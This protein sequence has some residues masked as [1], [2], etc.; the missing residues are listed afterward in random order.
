M[1][2]VVSS[3]LLITFVTKVVNELFVLRDCER[4]LEDE[5]RPI[6]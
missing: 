5:G 6:A 3:A 1:T 4:P 2:G